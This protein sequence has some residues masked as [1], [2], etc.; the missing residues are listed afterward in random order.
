MALIPDEWLLFWKKIL[1]CSAVACEQREG[2]E[3]KSN[4][5]AVPTGPFFTSHIYKDNIGGS[6][7]GG[8][9]RLLLG[10]KN[11]KCTSDYIIF[12]KLDFYKNLTKK[13]WPFEI[14]AH[15][16]I[17]PNF[18]IHRNTFAT[19]TCLKEWKCVKQ[20]YH[21]D[22]C[23]GTKCSEW[24]FAVILYAVHMNRVLFSLIQALSN[25]KILE[26]PKPYQGSALARWGCT[27]LPA[28]Q[29]CNAMIFG[30]TYR[31]PHKQLCE[32]CFIKAT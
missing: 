8:S 23:F 30:H 10:E 5:W 6:V 19:S 21:L 2:K 3:R 13:A 29:M 11:K 22:I 18:S 32:K 1:F 7:I 31:A 24:I 28:P 26:L 12:W 25:A 20:I 14:L 17:F 16:R 15:N 27:E 4:F 9:V